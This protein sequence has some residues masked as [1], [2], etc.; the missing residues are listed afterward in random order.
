MVYTYVDGADPAHRARREACRRE[1]A[2]SGEVPPE[3]DIWYRGVAEISYSV[4]SA[5]MAMPWLGTIHIVTDG[6]TPPI[7]KELMASGKVKLV[8]HA[9]IVPAEYRPV[10]AS[11]IIE[12]F[13]HRIP[14]LADIWLYNNDD[15]FNGG[16]IAPSMFVVPDGV[17]ND[18]L[19]LRTVPAWIR[20]T[21]RRAADWSPPFLP[22]ANPYTAGIA[23]AA[24]LA[25][26]H[27]GFAWRDIVFPRH[28][29]QVY[30]TS[31]A[32]EIEARFADELHAARL[33]HFRSTRQI[34]WSTLAYSMEC[35]LF[36]AVQRRHSPLRPKAD[37]LFVDFGRIRGADRMA[38]AWETIEH[39]PANFICL[40]NI[41]EAQAPA[42]ER[43][44]TQRGLVASRRKTGT[45]P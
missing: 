32:R 12:S 29:T 34:S 37:E 2:I 38:S 16:E 24:E 18:R 10:F 1:L 25:R 13:L 21:L 4:R 43:T 27:C 26:A 9:D 14:G 36:G 42:F 22:R 3:K 17:A 19:V 45:A 39:S 8:D 44:M 28:L 23:N 20:V 35:A 40:N 30:R 11:T 6:Q 5:L 7:D 41:P 15:F 33:R 31:T